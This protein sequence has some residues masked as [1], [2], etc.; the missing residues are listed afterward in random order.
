[1][2]DIQAL[3]IV[4]ST[5][6]SLDRVGVV[7]DQV[8][9]AHALKEYQQGLSNETTRRQ[10]A[11]LALFTRFLQDE[12]KASTGD[13]YGDLEAWRH[14]TFGIVEGFKRWQ[15]LQGVCYRFY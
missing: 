5:F 2:D 15:L 10:K 14:I 9:I 12:V 7:A 8:T 3:S 6:A 11:D 13:F 1:M 4:P